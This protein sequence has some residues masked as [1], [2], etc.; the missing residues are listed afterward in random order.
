MVRRRDPLPSGSVGQRPRH[1]DALGG[2]EGQVEPGHRRRPLPQSAGGIA[3]RGALLDRHLA[4]R[5]YDLRHAAVSLWLNAGV[6]ATQVS[7]WAGHS[8]NVLLRVY[9]KCVVGQDEASRQRV[10]AALRE[11]KRG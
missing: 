6:P 11:P 7:E 8:V 1:R 5:P 9:A 4:K 2:G 10:Q 3:A